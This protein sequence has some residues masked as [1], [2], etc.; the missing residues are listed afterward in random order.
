MYL[1]MGY[2]KALS[3]LL[4]G[5]TFGKEGMNHRT[6]A[7]NYVNLS[8]QQKGHRATPKPRALTNLPRKIALK[9]NLG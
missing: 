5:K 9:E 1:S 2:S 3:N 6:G 4:K 7:L 8:Y